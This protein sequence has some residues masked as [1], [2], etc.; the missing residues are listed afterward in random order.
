MIRKMRR[1][2][3][4]FLAIIMVASGMNIMLANI[5]AVFAGDDAQKGKVYNLVDNSYLGEESYVAINN[6]KVTPGSSVSVN[7]NDTVKAYLNWSLPNTITYT[8]DD[9]F[10]YNLPENLNV[11]STGGKL[12]EGAAEVGNFT[13]DGNKLIIKY[14][15]ET[16]LA[17]T[18][19]IGSLR[20]DGVITSL[21]TPN[22]NGGSVTFNFPGIGNI[23]VE[24]AR[25]TTNDGVKVKKDNIT[26]NDNTNPLKQS[27]KLA[28]TSTGTN[29]N[30]IFTDTMGEYIDLDGS[31]SFYTDENC[32]SSYLGATAIATDNG[33]QY[34]IASMQDGEV[35]YA[36]YS[37]N[38]SKDAYMSPQSNGNKIQNSA[39]VKS[40]EKTNPNTVTSSAKVSKTWVNKTGTNNDGVITWTVYIG[41]GDSIDIAGTIFKDT[42]GD[43]LSNVSDFKV[44]ERKSSLETWDNSTV[45]VENSSLGMTWSKISS[46]QGYTFPTGSTNQY[47]IVYT[48]IADDISPIGSDARTNAADVTPFG[49]GTKVTSKPSVDVGTGFSALDKQYV[50][51][52]ST[53]NE[54][55]WKITVTIPKSGMN[56]LVVSDNTD[57]KHSIVAN[58]VDITGNPTTC[59]SSPQITYTGTDEFNVD[60]GD[61]TEGVIDIEYRTKYDEEPT[62]TTTYSNTAYL[63]ATGV[64]QQTDTDRHEINIVSNYLNRKIFWYN[65]NINYGRIDW[66]ISV[67]ALPNTAENV[68]I[69]DTLPENTKLIQGTVYASSLEYGADPNQVSLP[70]IVNED[71]KTFTIELTSEFRNNVAQGNQFFIRY[72]TQ[73]TDLSNKATT[74]F[75][76]KAKITVD[77]ITYPEVTSDAWTTFKGIVDKEASYTEDS[78]PDVNYTVTLNKAGIDVNPA[79]DTITLVDRAGSALEFV[80]GSIKVNNTEITKLPKPYSY[81]Y[82][83]GVLTIVVPDNIPI[84]IEYIE[85]V[86]LNVGS[87][88]NVTNSGN[89][90]SI[91]GKIDD[92]MNSN[93]T[94]GNVVL[95]STGVSSAEGKNIS[96]YKYGNGDNTVPLENAEY[97]IYDI[98]YDNKFDALQ[99][100]EVIKITTGKDGYASYGGLVQDHIYKIIETKAPVGYEKDLKTY[101]FV[102]K[103]NDATVYPDK[104]QNTSLLKLEDN[105]S[106]YTF[107]FNNNESPVK[108]QIAINKIDA[109]VSNSIGSAEL[110][111]KNSQSQIVESWTTE[112]GKQKTI[113]LEAGVYTLEETKAPEGYNIADKITFTVADNGS[114]SIGGT[115]VPNSTVVMKDAQTS[116][117]VSISKVDAA[118]GVTELAG[119]TLTVA[120]ASGKKVTS[121]TS[122]GTA[123]KVTLTAGTYTLTED[124]APL[125]YDKAEKITFVVGKD[126][127]VTVAGTEVTKVIMKDSKIEQ[128]T[129]PSTVAPT[130]PSTVAPTEPQTESTAEHESTTVSELADGS[131]D[132]GDN[133]NMMLYVII[134]ICSISTMI[135]VI[136][137][138]NKQNM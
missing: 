91:S 114:V 41:K 21:T 30:V 129:E 116:H 85:R 80:M 102:Y 127:K 133:N 121:W 123:K 78:A 8:T 124:Q 53:T 11:T 22:T 117:E 100:Q 118:D 31:V 72:S 98:T 54:M 26:P 9:S 50:S 115:T 119:A 43:K 58:S 71:G 86:T 135:V 52:D 10:E 82:S 51:Y 47:K 93:T 18:D 101:Y 94:I 99:T 90:I 59:Y 29:T 130:E 132:T 125:G 88:L 131:I 120:D 37:V 6:Q 35:I 69:T 66:V 134:L 2:I 76:N 137:K 70:Y 95:Q 84:K 55:V 77:G 136:C 105:V 24:V 45:W 81:T 122:D 109:V 34:K 74:K 7:Y 113:M 49:T 108:H 126:G 92:T 40:D 110:T 38:V 48:T 25:D 128:P 68:L 79:G 44:Y 42:L 36:K 28:I 60:F 15:S 33:F 96:V 111:I 73:N 39:S 112:A 3:T 46:E 106:S 14:T 23:V 83:E 75:T 97:T 5:G 63:N 19:K 56:N 67:A 87:E 107:N 12:K 4:A 138:K 57:G 13:I 27:F 64:K 104:F 61:V 62:A 20:L 89:S 65:D 103:G 17:R 16:F 1:I 32:E